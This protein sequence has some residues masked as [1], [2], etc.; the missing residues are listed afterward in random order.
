MDRWAEIRLGEIALRVNIVVGEIEVDI[1][2][3]WVW[4]S[5][6]KQGETRCSTCYG[7]WSMFLLLLEKHSRL[8]R[9]G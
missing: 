6:D 2:R 5:V 3:P 4:L 8:F 9:P 7:E 1:T